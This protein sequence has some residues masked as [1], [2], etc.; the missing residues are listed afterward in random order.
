M[1]QILS[2]MTLTLAVLLCPGSAQSQIAVEA[3][4]RNY[5]G[6]GNAGD[7][8]SAIAVDV[9]DNIYVTGH[10]TGSA[11]NYDYTTIKHSGA[12]V[13]AWTNHY[14]GQNF[15]SDSANAVAVDGNGNV[16]VT[17]ESF[18]SS[19]SYDYATIQY[20]AMGVPLWTNRYNG[21]ING[22]DAALAMSLDIFGNVFVTG[23]SG[24]SGGGNDY[25]TIKYSNTGVPV[26]TNLYNGPA[27]GTDGASAIALDTD[28]NVLVTGVARGN[29]SLADYA[30][31]KYSNAGLSLWTNYY[32]GPGNNDDW[33]N[34]IAVDANGNVFVTGYQT[35]CGSGFD[36]ATIKY[37]GAGVPLWTNRYGGLVNGTDV[38]NALALDTNG[39]VFVTGY[40]GNGF[41]TAYATL[42]YSAMGVPLWTNRYNSANTINQATAIMVDTSSNV[43]VTGVSIN[44]SNYYQY[45]TIAYSGAGMPLWT[46]HY[47]GAGNNASFTDPSLAVDLSGNVFVAGYS[48]GV[49]TGQD[50]T[51]IKYSAIPPSLKIAFTSTNTIAVSWP[52]PSTDFTL[53]QNTNGIATMNWTDVLTMP[54][55]DGTTKTIIVDPPSGSRFYRLSKP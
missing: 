35:G 10:S 20:S 55:D 31:I 42:K 46:N 50:Y 28:G 30:T 43:F 21:P 36:Y 5:N 53:Q 44:T 40:S 22:A 18:N 25:A 6:L 7:H 52:S 4:V 13:A 34:A 1:K 37:S 15:N 2:L 24:A 45:A 8:P 9:N 29:G 19:T 11:G 41:S 12:G 27:N 38:A 23:Y 39:N 14:N 33:A 26:W 49:G 32:N 47:D 17:G 54:T 51:L 3:W 48:T 16:F